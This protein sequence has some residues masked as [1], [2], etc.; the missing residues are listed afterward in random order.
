[1]KYLYIFSDN[2]NC[3]SISSFVSQ[4]SIENYI[5][6]IKPSLYAT[7]DNQNIPIQKAE[8]ENGVL[9]ERE[10][11]KSDAVKAQEATTK[12][13]FLLLESDWTDTVSAQTRLGAKYQQW[14]D[15]R[16]AL[17][18]ITKQSGYPETINWPTTPQG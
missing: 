2:Q 15:Y 12:R 17:R 8:L 11:E 3:K 7:S 13:Y 9:V 10:K 6:E 1:M 16:Q 5:N 18:D 14:Q 4:Q